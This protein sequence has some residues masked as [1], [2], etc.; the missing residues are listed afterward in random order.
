[1]ELY[2]HIP[3]CVRKCRY[4]DF[5]SFQ[6]EKS[7]MAEYIRNLL[8]EAEKS[9]KENQFPD[10]ET[11]YI[12]GGTPSL[13]SD[14]LTRMLWEGLWRI[15]RI[16]P[17]AEITVEAN[18][19]TVREEWLDICLSNGVNRFSLGMQAAQAH[20]L[21]LLGRIHRL[22]E[23]EK[24]VSLFQ[25]K[26]V[27]N[28]NL[29]LM[30]GIPGQT[31]REWSDT[32]SAALSMRP[33]HLSCY[34]LIPEE[35]TPLKKELDEGLLLLPEPEEEREMYYLTKDIL[36]KNGYA[37]YEVSNF[38]KSGMECK[39]N[40]GYWTMTPYI[41]LGLAAASMTKIQK[42]HDGI[43][44]FRKSNPIDFNEYAKYVRNEPVQLDCELIDTAEARF[45]TVMLGL[46]MTQGIN[47]QFF[48]SLHGATLS[49][50][51]QNLLEGLTKRGLMCFENGFW[52]LT[53]TGMDIQNSVLVE[54]MQ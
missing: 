43:N 32:L 20:V 35:G 47:D 26:N 3:F 46:R 15:F 19:G 17:D 24:T 45:E 38:S 44:Y 51:Y 52:K 50:T 5:V 28:Y 13:L 6:A 53:D 8:L 30:F 1:M 9:N 18:P 22:D 23:V 33:S 14:E 27:Q 29:D 34:G 2:V 16:R 54:F 49:D 41:G 21:E 12:G 11:V 39:H 40:I 36:S 31:K 4:C 42:K 7:V 25:K 10:I 48:K 37:Q